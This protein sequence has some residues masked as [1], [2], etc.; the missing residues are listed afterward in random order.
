MSRRFLLESQCRSLQIPTAHRTLAA[1]IVSRHQI[2][3]FVRST[4]F[5]LLVTRMRHL[6]V[7]ARVPV[8]MAK[9]VT[10]LPVVTLQLQ[11]H[12]RRIVAQISTNALAVLQQLDVAGVCKTV[13]VCLVMHLTRIVR[14][15]A[16]MALVGSTL[17]AVLTTSLSISKFLDLSKPSVLSMHFLTWGYRIWWLTSQQQQRC[18]TKQHQFCTPLGCQPFQLAPHPA[19][20]AHRANTLSHFC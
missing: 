19:L 20:A 4:M 17:L 15:L 3:A 18:S 12:R 1:T 9:G 13:R 11:L 7:A 16:Q 14:V 10:S 2:A 6:Q 8:R 5:V